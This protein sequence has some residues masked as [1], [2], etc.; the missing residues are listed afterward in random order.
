[1]E[2]TAR[3]IPWSGK[4]SVAKAQAPG[5]SAVAPSASPLG[6][7]EHGGELGPLDDYVIMLPDDQLNALGTIFAASPLRKAMTFEGYL[8]VKGFGYPI[9]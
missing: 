7:P 1:M 9:R 6:A 2:A 4:P 5:S 8:I 3:V